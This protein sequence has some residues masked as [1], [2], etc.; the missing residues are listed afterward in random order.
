MDC[1]T[2]TLYIY[3][4][5]AHLHIY[6]YVVAPFCQYPLGFFLGV[7]CGNPSTVDSLPL[8]VFMEV[9]FMAL[10]SAFSVSYTGVSLTQYVLHGHIDL[11]GP[12]ALLL[13]AAAS[14][15]FLSSS[16]LLPWP[17]QLQCSRP[18]RQLQPCSHPYCC[19][20]PHWCSRCSSRQRP[21]SRCCCYPYNS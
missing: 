6:T 20:S 4:C 16:H 8:A 15:Y 7:S 9:S 18:S 12:T 10:S 14:A 2:H 17:P 21:C 13:A 11:L 3:R 5:S 1:Y 19:S